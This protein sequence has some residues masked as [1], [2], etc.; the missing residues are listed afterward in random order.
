MVNRGWLDCNSGPSIS[1]LDTTKSNE[2][3]G[4]DPEFSVA[5]DGNP[6]HFHGFKPGFY[7]VLS[8]VSVV[9]VVRK[10]FIGQIEFILSR[11]K[12]CIC[13][14]FCIEHLCGRFP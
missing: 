4:F 8:V 11:T 2:R 6:A 3:R 13:H 10:K 12:S 9:S 5:R 7:I 14:F 1:F